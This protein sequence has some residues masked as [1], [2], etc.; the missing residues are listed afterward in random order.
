MIV[1][2]TAGKQKKN[3]SSPWSWV[4]TL[5]LSQGLPFIIATSFSVIMYKRLGISNADIAL[6]TSWLYLPW[7]IKPLWSP[8]IDVFRTKRFWITFLQLTVGAGMAGVALTIPA[9]DFFQFSLAFFWIIAFSSATFDIA[10]DGF[11]MLAL[12]EKQQSFFIGIRSAFYKAALIGS[13]GLLVILAGQLEVYLTVQPV[14]IKVVANPEKFFENT[15]HVDTADVKSLPGNI[16]L[17]ATPSIVEI[18]TKPISEE[19]VKFYKSFA[20]KF[21]IMNGFI[22]SELTPPDTLISEKLVGNIG[23]VKFHLS[24]PPDLDKEYNV[25]LEFNE[26]TSGI[27]VIEGNTFRFNS[28]NWN[29]PA[30]AVIQVDPT[31]QKNTEATFKLQSD[32]VP[33]AWMFTFFVI[34]ILIILFF[35]YHKFILPQPITDKSAATFHRTAPVKEF[36]RAFA[37]FFERDKILIII[38][39]LLFFNLSEAQLIKIVNPFLMDQQTAGGLALTTTEVGLGYSTFGVIALII[40]GVLGGYVISIVGLKKMLWW[41]LISVNLPNLIY[42][43]FAF[44][45][46]SDLNIIYFSIALEQFGYGFGFT[47]LIMYMI[48]ISEGDYKTSHFSL[49][50]AF[51]V[52]GMMVPGMFS[53][54]IQ[55]AVGYQYFFIWIIFAAI[56]SFIFA[57]Y[58]PLDSTFGKRHNINVQ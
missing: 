13:Q 34:A 36:I 56:P 15:I 7:V 37:R 27:N 33:L 42:V 53:G 43:Y 28:K 45:Q 10:S 1:K 49:A 4:P 26:G 3:I 24:K 14:E 2:K 50:S 18:G 25:N 21:N 29:K 5:Y 9:P 48:Y 47:A 23:I 52:L 31:I 40:G 38:G 8:I 51:M 19:S 16:K 30:F 39:F 20:K 44:V 12:T 22:Q 54:I 17:I 32:K 41:M 6:Y 58:I 55:Q 11:Y 46:P 35:I 57:K